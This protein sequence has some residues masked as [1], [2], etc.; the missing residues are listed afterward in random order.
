MTLTVVILTK[1][2]GRHIERALESV[3]QVASNCYVVDSGSTDG[4]VEIAQSKG[5]I[6]LH[7][8]WVNYASQFNWALAQLPKDTDWVFRL[9]ADE[10]ITL[11]LEEEIRGKLPVV[12]PH[13]C[14]I[15]VSRRIHFLG[16]P[17]RW[18]GVF[19]VQVL[20]IFRHGYAHCENRWMD[21]HIVSQGGSIKISGEIIDDNHNSLTWWTDKHNSYA[22][23]EV[24]DI[25]NQ[26]YNFT[27]IETIASLRGGQQASIKRW[28]KEKVYSRLP[29]G[30]RALMYFLY[31]YIFRLGF[32]D[33][34]A[35][36][37]FHFLQGFWYRYLVDAKLREVK[38]HMKSSGVDVTDAIS[39]VL[40]IEVSSA[41]SKKATQ[42]A[43]E[44]HAR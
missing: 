3:A 10:V 32:L 41:Q 11:E 24:V 26:E 17:I 20:R 7:N 18:G 29:C 16:C 43:S 2:E 9:D 8:P 15:F 21:E 31:R 27:P 25:L 4:T 34:R 13:I 42:L 36:T 28:I 35:G 30:F 14:G 33:G 5:A 40:G 39:A 1:N 23:R 12:P 38:V 19:P 22:S 37:D 44:P 6:V